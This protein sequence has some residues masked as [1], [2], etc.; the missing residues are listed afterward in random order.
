MYT[1]RT[2]YLK[3]VYQVGEAE[4]GYG[5]PV[6]ESVTNASTLVN[7]LKYIQPLFNESCLAVNFNDQVTNCASLFQE[8]LTEI[9]ICQT[10][11]TLDQRDIYRP[12]T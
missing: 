3:A 1:S 5:Y 10:F 8:I 11:N 2:S 6:D 12:E 7:T 9:G 4:F